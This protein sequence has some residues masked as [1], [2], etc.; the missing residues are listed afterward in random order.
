MQERKTL[1]GA[2]P[3]L[4]AFT[5]VSAV[6]QLLWLNF[7]PLITLVMRRY[8]VGEGQASLLVL[9]FPLI[10]IFLS[11]HSG[12]LIDRYGF[13]RVVGYG[14]IATAVFSALRIYDESFW[15]LLAGQI[16]IAIAQPYVTNG[17]SKL[18][19]EWFDEG[20]GAIATGVGTI[21]LFVGMA[22]ALACTPALVAR[23]SLRTAMVVFAAV[24]GV[25][26][27]VFVVVAKDAPAPAI[28]KRVERKTFRELL[29]TRDLVVLLVLSFLGLGFFNGL[30]TWLEV[31]LKPNG[32]DAEGAGFVGG[33]LI[34]GGIF[35]AAVIPAISDAMRRRKP[36]VTVC[37]CV[38]AALVVPLCSATAFATVVALGGV[39]GFFFLPA[40]AL[41]L[42]MCSELAGRA[43]AGYA[44]G[45]LML[46][47]NA[48]GVVTIVAMDAVKGDGGNY[49][50]SVW[51]LLGLLIV[52]IALSLVVSE[53]FHRKQ[54][55]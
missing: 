15:V 53:T 29:R 55:T 34:V 1:P 25:S 39:L 7:A 10:Y 37:T 47:G 32:I 31:I 11:L 44:T 43:S 45:L 46:S 2:W 19:L 21:G 54:S 13:R 23:T 51:L 38:A 42:E 24:A 36:F 16:G 48:G 27:L 52:A 20:Q 50:P 22:A 33:A 49:R 12:T 9:V 4:L 18:V 28:G 35:G 5:L 40:Y 8:A 3:V 41:L 17:I 30:T 14:A 6:T 26:A